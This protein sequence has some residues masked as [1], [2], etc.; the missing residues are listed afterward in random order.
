MWEQEE[1]C[2]D[3][4]GMLVLS[5]PVW[6]CVCVYV[7]G[8]KVCSVW[9][10][11]E[12]KADWEEGGNYFREMLEGMEPIIQNLLHGIFNMLSYN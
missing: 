5:D 11:A 3:L 7:C 2:G 6:G 1:G 9:Q 10:P 4:T 8:A 12:A